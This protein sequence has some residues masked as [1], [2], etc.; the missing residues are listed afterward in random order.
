MLTRLARVLTGDER[1]EAVMLPDGPRVEAERIVLPELDVS[2]DVLT[3]YLDMLAARRK[4]SDAAAIDAIRA[5]VEQGLAQIIDDRRACGRLLARYPGAGR[6]LM[7]WREHASR[8]ASK[9]WHAMSWRDRLLWLI[10]RSMWDETFAPEERDASLRST[11]AAC[12]AQLDA[13]RRA[14]STAQSIEASRALVATVRALAST[15]FNTMMFTADADGT[16][17]AENVSSAFD[18][19]EDGG[20]ASTSD[21][22]ASQA[23]AST[24]A[25]QAAVFATDEAG[26]PLF[27]V[28]FTTEFD[29]ITDMTGKGDASAWRSLLSLARAETSPLKARL[30]RA[31]RADE[32]TH[33]HRE[34]ERGELDRHALPKLAIAPGYRTPFRVKRVTKGRDA[35]VCILI[36][37]SG[38]M[39]GKKIELARLCAAALA[40]ALMQLSF[41]CE[42][43]GYSSIESP[44]MRDAHDAA[45]AGGLDMRRFNRF[46]ERLDLTVYK[47]FESNVLDGLAAIECGHENPDGEALAWAADRLMARRASRRILMVLSDGYPATGDGHPVVLRNDLHERVRRITHDGI[48]LIGVGVL[49]DAVE[50]FYPSSIVVRTLHELPAQAF[51][52]LASALLKR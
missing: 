20:D 32:Q 7:Q 52:A 24:D 13:A 29:R 40:D 16:L 34:Q 50:Q 17:D 25:A 12:E 44:G 2:R 1:I 33:W 39:A 9:R 19:I 36:D 26:R 43:L 30:E 41:A 21:P 47:R 37:R 10:E 14:Q 35:A 3:G 51:N 46:V 11:L 15:S 42:V 28:P 45:L 48:E 27:S 18:D 4:Y 38:S 6:Y 31:L 8:D 49:D 23:D 5:P 22:A